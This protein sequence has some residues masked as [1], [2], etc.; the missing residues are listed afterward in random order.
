MSRGTSGQGSK[1]P[2]WGR[3]DGQRDFAAAPA[4]MLGLVDKRRAPKKLFLR[5]GR[6]RESPDTPAV[7]AGGEGPVAQRRPWPRRRCGR[8][9]PGGGTRVPRVLACP[10]EPPHIDAIC[11]VTAGCISS[12]RHLWSPRD[13]S[14]LGP[15]K[16]QFR[17]YLVGGK[18]RVR[19]SL[20]PRRTTEEAEE[21]GGQR[22]EVM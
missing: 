20:L 4:R 2:G 10:P 19:P 18:P 11:I 1:G 7:M 14:V 16:C 22:F 12:T 5:W 13:Y 3:H 6:R 8:E 15:S 17:H 9:A 21:S